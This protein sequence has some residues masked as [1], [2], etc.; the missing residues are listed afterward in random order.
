MFIPW[1]LGECLLKP[2]DRH[3]TSKTLQLLLSLQPLLVCMKT[4]TCQQK[5]TKCSLC[6]WNCEKCNA[7]WKQKLLSFKVKVGP[8]QPY[9]ESEPS[10]FPVSAFFKLHYFLAN[11]WSVIA[12]WCLPCKQ[13]EQHQSTSNQHSHKEFFRSSTL[14]V[15][16]FIQFHLVI[17]TSF[18]LAT[19][20]PL[21]PSDL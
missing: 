20:V 17:T 18:P 13:W 4:S 3:V 10:T 9:F 15:T 5:H 8:V 11:S 12:S 16:N 14:F 7:H 21:T 1:P 6:L 19:N 2:A